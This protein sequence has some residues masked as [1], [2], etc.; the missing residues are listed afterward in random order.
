MNTKPGAS[1]TKEGC[2][3]LGQQVSNP[4]QSALENGPTPTVVAAGI[5][6][7]EAGTSTGGSRWRIVVVVVAVL[8]LARIIKSVVTG[9]APVTLELNNTLG[10]NTNN[11]GWYTHISHLTRFM[12]PPETYISEIGGQSTMCQVCTWCIRLITR[13]CKKSTIPLATQERLPR[14][15]YT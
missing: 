11:P 8:T 10:K 4:V 7:V 1:E 6:Q 15:Y 13:A 2:A 3:D 14:I 12:P 9:H 5:G